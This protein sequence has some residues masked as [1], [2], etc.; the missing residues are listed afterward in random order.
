MSRDFIEKLIRRANV[1]FTGKDRVILRNGSNLVETF[2]GKAYPKIFDMERY[3]ELLESDAIK[4]CLEKNKSII[5]NPFYESLLYEA[6]P[7]SNIVKNTLKAV[8]ESKVKDVES[9]HLTKVINIYGA[10]LALVYVKHFR[11]TLASMFFCAS[12]DHG[13]Y[14]GRTNGEIKKLMKVSAEVYGRMFMSCIKQVEDSDELLSLQSILSLLDDNC[15]KTPVPLWELYASNDNIKQVMDEI[16]ELINYVADVCNKND[17]LDLYEVD[18]SS[19]LSMNRLLTANNPND[20]AEW[21]LSIINNRRNIEDLMDETS[22]ITKRTCDIIGHIDFEMLEKSI[23]EF[24]SMSIVETTGNFDEFVFCIDVPDEEPSP[25][26]H[27]LFD[28]ILD[29]INEFI[30][31]VKEC[32]PSAQF[33]IILPNE[34]SKLG[35]MRNA[36]IFVSSGDYISFSNDNE[37]NTDLFSLSKYVKADLRNNPNC[38]NIRYYMFM[39]WFEDEGKRIMYN[40]ISSYSLSGEI[41]NRLFIRK[42]G[43]FN[44]PLFSNEATGLN[45]ILSTL[46]L[47]IKHKQIYII[48]SPMYCICYDIVHNIECVKGEIPHIILYRMFNLGIPLDVLGDR[49]HFSAL[50]ELLLYDKDKEGYNEDENEEDNEDEN[51]EDNEDENE[52]DN[53]DENEEFKW[54]MYEENKCEDARLAL[55]N[56]LTPLD[57]H[58]AIDNVRC[59]TM[60]HIRE[61]DKKC[62]K[63][64]GRTTN[65]PGRKSKINMTKDGQIFVRYKDGDETKDVDTDNFNRI[66]NEDIRKLY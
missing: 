34:N 49:L 52:E 35:C 16:L 61:G 2:S 44:S 7:I 51:E 1:Y 56:P 63:F 32:N 37:V 62:I 55:Q 65:R 33:K 28:L 26:Y 17:I 9:L 38:M 19:Q 41:I 12:Y 5:D 43:L 3:S 21:L 53:E 47:F 18:D 39:R 58:N 40:T 29:S 42:M 48:E 15:K 50:Y 54:Y 36:A 64:Y 4:Q 11:L 13:C 59:F 25:D 66:A 24:K 45:F 14:E 31:M 46:D 10:D 57:G 8:K 20:F 6:N 60:I 30:D 22:E 23:E 27:E